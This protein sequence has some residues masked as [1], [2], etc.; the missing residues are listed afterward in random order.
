MHYDHTL[1]KSRTS[2]SPD[3]DFFFK[4][5]CGIALSPSLEH[6][7]QEEEGSLK[8]KVN[9]ALSWIWFPF[10]DTAFGSATERKTRRESERIR[11][12]ASCRSAHR[13]HLAIWHDGLFRHLLQHCL[14]LC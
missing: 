14:A 10:V 7:L 8:P 1:R 9:L 12:K 6:V 5:F 13:G 4:A 2:L 3:S 11:I